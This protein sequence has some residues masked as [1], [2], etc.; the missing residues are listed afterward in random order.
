MGSTSLLTDGSGNAGQSYQYRPFGELLGGGTVI[1]PYTYAGNDPVNC[2][3]PS[4]QTSTL[5]PGRQSQQMGPWKTALYWVAIGIGVAF[6]EDA[7]AGG[8][9][10]VGVGDV[11]RP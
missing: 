11:A 10:E 1:N 2:G 4:G 8:E 5:H 3:D 7:F 9:I 6:G